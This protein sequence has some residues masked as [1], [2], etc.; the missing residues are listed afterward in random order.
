MLP[1]KFG[2]NCLVSAVSGI[3]FGEHWN[4]V[5]HILIRDEEDEEQPGLWSPCGQKNRNT[6]THTLIK[7]YKHDHRMYEDTSD[8]H[9]LAASFITGHGN[10]QHDS[11]ITFVWCMDITNMT[12][13]NY[14]GDQI[15]RIFSLKSETKKKETLSYFLGFL[16]GNIS[17]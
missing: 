14:P 7:Y 6:H 10:V 11:L 8:L 5:A 12:K 15:S 17:N 4:T 16:D 1:G 2:C 13:S 3:H 9:L